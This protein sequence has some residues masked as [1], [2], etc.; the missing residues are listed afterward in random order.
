[1]QTKEFN[2]QVFPTFRV[3]HN[4]LRGVMLPLSGP[5]VT[6]T[7]PVGVR[8]PQPKISDMKI[9]QGLGG[10]KS[11]AGDGGTWAWRAGTTKS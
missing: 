2:L 6:V 5:P 10:G 8:H 9:N 3:F 4:A 7:K 1:M 11:S